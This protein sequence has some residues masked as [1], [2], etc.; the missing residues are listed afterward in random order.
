VRTTTVSKRG[1]RLPV[2][3]GL[4]VSVSDWSGVSLE[5][6]YGPELTNTLTSVTELKAEFHAA[7]RG[8]RVATFASDIAVIT[9]CFALNA[10]DSSC[11]DTNRRPA[12]CATMC[13]GSPT[14]NASCQ[15]T[16]YSS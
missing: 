11:V 14:S 15:S 13:A 2:Y 4:A 10:A 1:F 5:I 9:A 16:K 7:A 12:C 6:V 8:A 3:S